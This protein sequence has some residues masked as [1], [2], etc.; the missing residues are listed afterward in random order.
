MQKLYNY[1]QPARTYDIC[2]NCATNLNVGPALEG[3]NAETDVR[4][5]E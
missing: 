2:C 4:V 3:R 5:G 1:W